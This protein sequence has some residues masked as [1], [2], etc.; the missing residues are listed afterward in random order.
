MAIARLIVQSS[1]SVHCAGGNLLEL[2]PEDSSVQP[3]LIVVQGVRTGVL[4]REP[5]FHLVDIRC[6]RQT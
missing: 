3:A 4:Q 5:V 6:V 2:H 1:R